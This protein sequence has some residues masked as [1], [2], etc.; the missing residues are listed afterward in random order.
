MQYKQ[1]LM[2]QIEQKRRERE[3]QR[4]K[5][6]EEEARLNRWVRLPSAFWHITKNCGLFRK[7][8]EQLKSVRLQDELEHE[9]RPRYR[10]HHLVSIELNKPIINTQSKKMPATE[11]C[12]RPI[13][14]NAYRAYD[15]RKAQSDHGKENFDATKRS[16]KEIYNFFTN[17]ARRQ[18]KDLR[19]SHYFDEE[20]SSE[21]DAVSVA[22][23]AYNTYPSKSSGHRHYHNET[24]QV[25]CNFCKNSRHL[26]RSQDGYICGACA[27]DPICLSCRKEICMR[28][29]RKI[30]NDE[31]AMPKQ[32][33][34]Q[35]KQRTYVDNE[36]MDYMKA[37]ECPKKSQS[38]R[39]DVP[40]YIEN[41]NYQEIQTEDEEDS[42]SDQ[43]SIWD[44]KP[45]YSFN[46]DKSSIFHPSKSTFYHSPKPKPA[47]EP[48]ANNRRLSVSIRN[49]ETVIQPDS[50]DE[51][52]R[53]T[54]EK[55]AKMTKTY[56]KNK[57]NQTI[58]S[59]EPNDQNES[60]EAMLNSM[61]EDSLVV[62]KLRENTKRLIEFAKELERTDC[63]L[64]AR[65][66]CNE[67]SELK[68]QASKLTSTVLFKND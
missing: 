40:P 49:G 48:P 60:Y 52:K 1:E 31:N 20:E 32:Q 58:E 51:L 3:L 25:L 12:A 65:D 2:A 5:D 9:R 30:R 42:L 41:Y 57:S 15:Q 6:E 54:D 45:P 11:R 35:L 18:L 66:R 39:D 56:Q 27:S 26:S 8:E 47:L 50:F 33:P 24:Q 36:L 19:H 67:K 16:D 38:V 68:C 62:P 21:N 46:I 53:I 37:I 59:K 34:F 61:T 17:S 29:K 23:S 63:N 44:Q 28:C 10:D 64:H 13:D 22:S 14:A 7:L 55:L 4:L 43:S